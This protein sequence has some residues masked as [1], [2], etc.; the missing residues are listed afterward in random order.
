M[1]LYKVWVDY[2]KRNEGY[3]VTDSQKNILL[4]EEYN[5]AAKY[6]ANYIKDLREHEEVLYIVYS[7]E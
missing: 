1:K 2:P 6:S 4:F 5:D 3:F 7:V